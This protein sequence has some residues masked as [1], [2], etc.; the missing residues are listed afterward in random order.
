MVTN[1]FAKL[2]DKQ[3]LSIT[4]LRIYDK[5]ITFDAAD[6][7]SEIIKRLVVYS[8][9]DASNIGEKF[10]V[11][12]KLND[13]TLNGFMLTLQ[14]RLDI[15]TILFFS[16]FTERTPGTKTNLLSQFLTDFHN[17]VPCLYLYTGGSGAKDSLF[18]CVR[19]AIA[20]GNI[21]KKEKYYELFSVSQSKSTTKDK[22]QMPL[23][24]FLRIYRIGKL[25]EFYSLLDEYR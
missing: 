6:L 3:M 8:P 11:F 1:T 23:T 10:D 17:N 2:S 15:S 18:R 24:F 19:N 25:R 5:N 16:S 13:K 12:R 20:H 7:D 14:K 21:V 9:T 22:T 4:P